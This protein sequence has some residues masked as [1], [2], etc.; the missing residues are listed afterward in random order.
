[1]RRRS[2]LCEFP[3]LS[4]TTS[5]PRFSPPPPTTFTILYIRSLIPLS[6]LLAVFDSV[7]H[8]VK[9]PI[10]VRTTSQPRSLGRLANTTIPVSNYGNAQ[11]YSNITIAGQEVS[12]LQDPG[13]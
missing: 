13:W 11:Y 1:M 2:N 5:T 12:V 4:A 10:D 3:S 8:A 7:A 9:L 6:L